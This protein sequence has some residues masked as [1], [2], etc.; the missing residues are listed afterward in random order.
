MAKGPCLFVA[1]IIWTNFLCNL[2]PSQTTHLVKQHQASQGRATHPSKPLPTNHILFFFLL[3]PQT[4]C[5]LC[6]EVSGQHWSNATFP[7]FFTVHSDATQPLLFTSNVRLHF[8]LSSS[9]S[10]CTSLCCLPSFSFSLPPSLPPF[11]LSWLL[12]IL[13][14]SCVE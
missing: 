12:S 3:Q 4:F 2:F 8:L 13:L 14:L 10:I 6:F 7:P 5:L 9:I 1:L 11:I